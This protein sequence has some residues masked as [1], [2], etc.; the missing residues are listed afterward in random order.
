MS[1]WRAAFAAQQA[2][3]Q[4][5]GHTITRQAFE[6]L[7]RTA[8]EKRKEARDCERRLSVDGR[9][10]AEWANREA[11]AARRKAKDI[12]STGFGRPGDVIELER[13]AAF[14]EGLPHGYWL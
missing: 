5:K 6:Q 12:R 3:E 10:A 13:W 2:V 8:E 4:A 14:L 11:Q 7:Q 1:K 9:V